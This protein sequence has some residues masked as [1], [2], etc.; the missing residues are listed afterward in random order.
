MRACNSSAQMRTKSPSPPQDTR[1]GADEAVD[2]G[3]IPL[4]LDHLQG[5]FLVACL[6]WGASVAAFL[7]E[8]L[9]GT[10]RKGKGEE[11]IETPSFQSP[12]SFPFSSQRD[13]LP[14]VTEGNTGRKRNA[15]LRTTSRS[16]ADSVQRIESPY[17]CSRVPLSGSL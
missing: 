5:I 13:D 3:V 12:Q 6:G 10:R 2:S 4:T 8:I 11:A 14:K 7:G 16:I 17:M 15:H 1:G 9:T